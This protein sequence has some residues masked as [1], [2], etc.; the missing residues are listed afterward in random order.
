MS[1]HERDKNLFRRFIR[2]RL[3]LYLQFNAPCSDALARKFALP[4]LTTPPYYFCND[5]A[6]NAFLNNNLQ[7]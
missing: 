6:G 2:Q 1:A 5:Q 7:Q 4:A 3:L